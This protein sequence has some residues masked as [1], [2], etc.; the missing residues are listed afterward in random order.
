MKISAM[1][2]TLVAVSLCAG[3]AFAEGSRAPR[4]PRHLQVLR[5][6]GDLVDRVYHHRA[7]REQAAGRHARAERPE[8]VRVA[9]GHAQER[10]RCSDT[11]VDCPSRAAI[12]RSR[13]E[14]RADAAGRRA[15]QPSPLRSKAESR[16]RCSDAGECSASSAG[17]RRAWA[18]RSAGAPAAQGKERAAAPRDAAQRQS[19]RMACNEGEECA[20]SSKE[21]AKFWAAQSIKAGTKS[22]SQI[23]SE[24]SERA[25]RVA[26]RQRER[27]AQRATSDA[28]AK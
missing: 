2:S 22:P 13:A 27:D 24:R 6:R 7:P 5:S 11:G 14:A 4:E 20:M 26:E 25:R 1:V 15:A 23:A 18:G 19:P 16:M 12:H 28:A 8:P 3:V 9:R 21:A 10:I 17:A